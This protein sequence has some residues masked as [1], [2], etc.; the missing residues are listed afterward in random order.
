MK[1]WS[2]YSTD[3]HRDAD[4]CIQIRDLGKNRKGMRRRLKAI[5]REAFSVVREVT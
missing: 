4:F 2:P 1:G 3:V 5:K